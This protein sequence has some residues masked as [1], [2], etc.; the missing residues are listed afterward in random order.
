MPKFSPNYADCQ[1]GPGAC[2]KEAMERISGAGTLLVCVVDDAGTLVGIVTDSDVRKALLAG[3]S[4]EDRIDLW[5]NRNPVVAPDSASPEDLRVLAHDCGVRELPLVDANRKVRDVYVLGSRDERISA[6]ELP[7]QNRGPTAVISSPL[8]ILAGGKGTRL[9]SVVSD[10]PKPLAMVGG[11]PMIDTVLAQAATAGFQK[12]FVAVNF[13]ADRIEEHLRQRKNCDLDISLLREGQ[14]LGTAGC[15]G[16]LRGKLSESVV[17]TNADVLTQLPLGRLVS[18]HVTGKHDL[19]CVVREYVER[20]PY[21]V[22]KIDESKIV[23]VEEKPAIRF[24]VN[25]GI[26]AI[27]PRVLE[28]VEPDQYLDMPT[29]INRAVASGMVVKP[30]MSHE[31]WLD[32]GRPDDYHKAN[33]EYESIFGKL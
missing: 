9:R 2:L 11:R 33:Q 22:V 6:D 12:I 25:T 24:L 28:L 21:G 13:M 7:G 10:R 31:Y 1:I 4:M 27:H 16:M 19:T 15:L 3:A 32:V 20:V 5:M 26:Y 8:L 14:E 18:A 30:F 23:G 17:V 29:L